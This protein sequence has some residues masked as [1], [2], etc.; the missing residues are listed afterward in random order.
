MI[1]IAPL[2][3]GCSSASVISGFHIAYSDC[4]P[5]DGEITT[6]DLGLTN[7]ECDPSTLLDGIMRISIYSGEVGFGD[8]FTIGQDMSAIWCN[9]NIC[10]NV[11][12]GNLELTAFEDGIA[13]S[14]Y[15]DLTLEDGTA[16]AGDLG[17]EWCDFGQV[18]CG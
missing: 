2:L 14:G 3:Y 16:F 11:V 4:G 13:V 6:I 12:S 9:S 5:D 10:E 8:R 7:P 18:M 15:Y 1:L 17:A